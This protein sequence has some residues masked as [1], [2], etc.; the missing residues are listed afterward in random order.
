MRAANGTK[1][2]K[3]VNMKK[4]QAE[5]KKLR[6]VLLYS[7][8]HLGSSIVLNRLHSMQEIDIVG[9][10]RAEPAAFSITGI[11]K[12][13][14]KVKNIGVKF[15]FLLMWQR[16]IQFIGFY[17]VAPLIAKNH[18]MA[19]WQFAR[20]HGIPSF[21]TKNINNEASLN[22]LR[23]LQP[24][25]IISAYFSQ[26]LKKPA[27]DTATIGVLNIHPALLPDYRGAMNYFWVLKNGEEKAGVSIHWIDEGIDTGKLLA[28][29]SF[30]LKP[31]STQQQVLTKTAF[32][33]TILLKKVIKSLAEGRKPVEIPRIDDNTNY[34]PMPNS[35]DFSEYFARRR[36]F[37]IRDIIKLVLKRRTIRGT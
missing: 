26:I 8:G 2:A 35:A 28:R 34:Y 14:N 23:S 31:D 15:G 5:I 32:I 18:L 7:A 4:E 13:Y 24:D 21:E 30:L 37:R 12:R 17:V 36:F 3:F 27:I 29:K 9:V 6:C 22:F 19:A 11:K 25:I 16:F 1:N 10:I 33:G 20:H